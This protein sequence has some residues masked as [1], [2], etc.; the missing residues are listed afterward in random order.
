MQLIAP[1]DVVVAT[2]PVLGAVKHSRS[3]RILNFNQLVSRLLLTM[4]TSYRSTKIKLPY[5]YFEFNKLIAYFIL[6]IFG[7][8]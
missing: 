7:F 2:T 8:K 6:I 5:F 4:T 3:I 1:V